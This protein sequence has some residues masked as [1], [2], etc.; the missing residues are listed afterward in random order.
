MAD[1]Y[2]KAWRSGNF[3]WM[4]IDVTPIYELFGGESG[5]SKYFSTIG[6]FQDVPKFIVHPIRSAKHKQSVV[7]GIGFE[8]LTGS[9][10]TGRRRFTT[11][12]ELLREGRTVRW[13][14]GGAIDWDQFPAYALSQIAGTQPIQLQ[15]LMAW[16]TGEQE[17]FDALSQSIGLR[18][19][20][21]YEQKRSMKKGLRKLKGFK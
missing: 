16:M 5:Q 8:A 11:L 20:T 18:T 10:Y 17:G 19:T 2:K 1:R 21:T 13:G 14:G 12:E 6:H 15:A 7:S 3:N 9:D 4:K